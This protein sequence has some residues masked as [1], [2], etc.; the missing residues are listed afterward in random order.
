MVKSSRGVIEQE[1]FPTWGKRERGYEQIKGVFRQIT[2]GKGVRDNTG[3][4]I[5]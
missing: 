4:N 5:D 2:G 3:K 1:A